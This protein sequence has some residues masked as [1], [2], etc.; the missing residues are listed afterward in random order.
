MTPSSRRT[1]VASLFALAGA[2]ASTVAVSSVAADRA[3]AVDDADSGDRLLEVPV[4]DGD[5]V[6]LA[7]THSVER[8]PVRDVY[9]VDG[10]ELRAERMVFHSHGAGLPTENVER[11]DEGFVVEGTGR[12]RNL[13]VTPGEIAGHELVVDGE[14]Y[15]LVDRADGTVVLSLTDVS[16]PDALGYRF[17]TMFADRRYESIDISE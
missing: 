9:V 6:V 17:E 2:G 14:R 15:D 12:Y 3:L 4:D 7:Y 11:T 5:E 1:F 8:T 13:R 16:I 10:S